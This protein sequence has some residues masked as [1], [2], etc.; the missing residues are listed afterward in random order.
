MKGQPVTKYSVSTGKG[1]FL[2]DDRSG[3]MEAGDGRHLHNRATVL[4]DQIAR[5]L[6]SRFGRVAGGGV[7]PTL[8]YGRPGRSGMTVEGET[9]TYSVE[10][11]KP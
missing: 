3:G 1:D 6:G 8:V 5:A 2:V 11:V 4:A 7:H 9:T 10:P